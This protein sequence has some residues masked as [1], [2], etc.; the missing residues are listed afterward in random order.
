MAVNNIYTYKINHSLTLTDGGL[1]GTMYNDVIKVH[2]GIDDKISFQVFDENRRPANISL[3]TLYLNVMNANTGDLAVQKVPTIT[4]GSNGKFDV[5]FSWTDTVNLDQGFYEF[6]VT[7]TDLND[8]QNVMYVDTSQNAIGAIELIEGVI[9]T[10][11]ASAIVTTFVLNGTRYESAGI[12]VSPT[13]NYQTNLHTCALYATT[14]AGSFWVEGSLDL[15]APTNWFIVD[16]YPNNATADHLTFSTSSPLTGI[17]ASN[18]RLS[19]NWLRFVYEHDAGNT[20]TIDKVL[21]RS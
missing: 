2:K 15:D 3:L 19:C 10:P 13:K 18:F 16:L 14:W 11:S 4:D 5:L 7:S 1:S 9:P 12:D 17:D 8:E 20:G 21:H 6:S